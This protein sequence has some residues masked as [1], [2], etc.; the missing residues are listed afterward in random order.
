MV[1]ITTGT[2]GYYNG[3]KVIP[4]TSADGPQRFDPELE[5]RLVKQGIAQYVD[6]APERREESPDSPDG[7][8]EYDKSMKLDALKKIAGAYGVDAAAM[9]RKAEVIEAIEAA[10]AAARL[11]GG[12]GGDTDEGDDTGSDEDEA[13]PQFGAAEPV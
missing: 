1:Q 7:L 10:K 13:P 9:T 11:D 12:E 8:P 4:I 5:A 3:R 6:A 2:F